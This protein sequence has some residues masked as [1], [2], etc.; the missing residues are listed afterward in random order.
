MAKIV[1]LMAERALLEDSWEAVNDLFYERGWTDGLPIVPPT[2]QRVLKML[3]YTDREPQEVVADVPPAGTG[4]TVE[5]IAINTVMAGCLPSYLPVIITAVEAMTQPEFNLY[6]LQCTTNPV[7]P[8]AILNG[9]V[10]KELDVN[11]GPN[12]LGQGRRS[13]ATIGRAIRLVLLNIGGAAPGTV[14]KATQGQ[15]AKYSFCVAEYEE[16]N[17]WEPLHVERGFPREV[18]TVTVVGASGTTNIIVASKNGRGILD[19]V[20]DALGAVGSNNLRY[21]VGEPLI[22]F[23]PEMAAIVARDGYSKTTAKQYVF[24][25]CG[26]PVADLPK[27]FAEE[28]ARRR[29]AKVVEVAYPCEKA[30]DIMIMV[31]GGI[32]CHTTLLPTFGMTTAVTKP[33]ALKNGSPVASVNDFRKPG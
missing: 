18:S 5:A 4:A 24:E 17:P 8:L 25:K 31:A 33:I 15:P 6:G 1:K 7:A 29:E 22:V 16:A 10:A 12:C 3:E 26:R 21:G 32:L 13:N 30:D 11:S 9:P 20:A 14:D 2:E 27:Q 28:I 19:E 23:P